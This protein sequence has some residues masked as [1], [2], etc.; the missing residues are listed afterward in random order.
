MVA[1]IYKVRDNSD[2]VQLYKCGG[3]L[4]HPQVVMTTSHCVIDLP[5]VNDIVIRA[6]EWDTQVARNL[7]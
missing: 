6:G 4:I 5:N 3:S 2:I 1:V 7:Y